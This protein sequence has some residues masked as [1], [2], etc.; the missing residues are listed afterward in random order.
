MP[1]L[2]Q[3]NAKGPTQVGNKDQNLWI[4]QCGLSSKQPF[5]DGSH[6]LTL[7]EAPEKLYRYDS[8]HKRSELNEKPDIYSAYPLT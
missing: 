4:C 8:Q 3:H 7:N 5:C 6:N 2:V 1:R